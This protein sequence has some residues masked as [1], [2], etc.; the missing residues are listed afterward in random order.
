MAECAS[1]RVVGLHPVVPTPE[2][3]ER[4]RGIQWGNDLVGEEFEN[5]N[6]AVRAHFEGLHLIEI[7]VE[8]PDCI[9]DWS[10]ITQPIAGKPSSE[11]QVPWDERPLGNGRWAFFLHFVQLDKPLQTSS[12]IVQLPVPTPIPR[13]LERVQYDLPG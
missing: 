5:A 8:P 3:F 11:W 7:Q 1:I 9:V 2:E 4:A 13:H 10:A 12:G 6:C